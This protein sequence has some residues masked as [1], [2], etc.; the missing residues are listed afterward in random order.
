MNSNFFLFVDSH[1]IL[2]ISKFGEL[3]FG[4]TEFFFDKSRNTDHT[5]FTLFFKEIDIIRIW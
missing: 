4:G 5:C 2:E 1:E 3:F